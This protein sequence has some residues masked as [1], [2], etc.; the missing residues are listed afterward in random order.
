M[1]SIS[2]YE[3]YGIADSDAD[4]GLRIHVFVVTDTLS[5]LA[6][7]YYGDWRQWRLIA[8]RNSI[9][10]PRQMV[11]GTELLIPKRPLEKGSYEST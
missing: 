1:R 9:S 7:R 6:H 8:E 4:T 10:D 3:R 11:P 2:P 5:G